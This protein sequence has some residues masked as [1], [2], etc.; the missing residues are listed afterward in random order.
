MKHLILLS[1]LLFSACGSNTQTA[2]SACAPDNG[3]FL[4]VFG[5]SITLGLDGNSWADMYGC[6]K[7]YKIVNM[8]I[9]GTTIE[10]VNQYP[11]LMAHQRNW[12]KGDV[13]IF[14]PGENDAIVYGHDAAHVAD[15][16]SKMTDIISLLASKN[17]TAYIGTPTYSCNEAL[18]GLN[19]D[20]DVY[21]GITRSII[22]MQA[23][24][25]VS[26]I[27]FTPAFTPTMTSTYDC[28]H[29]NGEGNHEMLGLIRD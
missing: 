15:Y 5:D 25:S 24:S 21:A 16:T 23:S 22:A 14:S 11:L 26:L 28:L 2:S 29:P 8:S 19:S 1:M 3:H 12:A 4:Y 7:G 13:I 9:G 20:R 6:A 18:F 10:A 17:I 27:D